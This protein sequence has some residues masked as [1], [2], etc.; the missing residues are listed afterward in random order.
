MTWGEPRDGG[1]DGSTGASKV[2]RWY[3]AEVVALVG[4]PGVLAALPLGE[5]S[6]GYQ[7]KAT[8]EDELG[9]LWITCY[10]APA[11]ARSYPTRGGGGDTRREHP[12]RQGVSSPCEWLRGVPRGQRLQRDTLTP[13]LGVR[14]LSGLST[15]LL[16]EAVPEIVGCVLDLV[17][18]LGPRVLDV[19]GGVLRLAFALKVL[20]TREIAGGLFDPAGCLVAF[21]THVGL[22]RD[23][24]RLIPA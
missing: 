1:P 9:P 22:L 24:E 7:L 23:G 3:E 16:L 8:L 15:V 13:A 4:L 6:D 17:A 18:D 5:P 14:P 12:Q 20:V 21:S 2:Q 10:L 11:A 19:A